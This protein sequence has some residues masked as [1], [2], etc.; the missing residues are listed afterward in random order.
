MSYVKFNGEDIPSFLKVTDISFPAIGDI[1][2]QESNAPGRIGS[3]DG[4]ITRGGKTIS[5]TCKIIKKDNT[6]HEYA[7]ALKRWAKGDNWKVS[8]LEFGEQDGYYLNARVSNSIDIDDLYATGETTIEFYA[9]D[10][11]KYSNRIYE[12]T[13]RYPDVLYMETFQYYG[14][15]DTPLMIELTLNRD[16]NRIHIFDGA[17]GKS[18]RLI[19]YFFAGDKI[20]VDSNKKV[21]KVNGDVNMKYFDMDN[22]WLYGSYGTNNISLHVDYL[23]DHEFK[24][25]YRE[26][27]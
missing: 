17:N 11:L 27:N 15:E 4:G 7:D 24:V 14:I 8:K 26:V 13:R 18:I 19:G 23:K 21:V 10:P 20:T 2:I 6:I 16:S 1:S 5:L 22:E 3:I 25:Y 12:S 9:A